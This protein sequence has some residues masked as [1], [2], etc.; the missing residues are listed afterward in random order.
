M[1]KAFTLLALSV[2]CLAAQ[3]QIPNGSFENWT[4]IGSYSI[5][6]GWDNFNS[7]TSSS[8]I[9]TCEKGTT[10]APNGSAYLKLTTKTVGSSLV[11]GFAQTGVYDFTNKTPKS[12]FAFT[13]RPASLTGKWQYMASGSDTSRIAVYLTKWNSTTGQTDLIA[14]VEYNLPGM[15]MSWTSFSIPLTYYSNSA[16]DSAIVAAVTSN[17][18]VTAAAG[19]YLYLDSLNFA[20]T[21]AGIKG[22][23]ASKYKLIVSPNP[24]KDHISIDFGT[25]TT[26]DAVIS[27]TDLFG[28]IVTEATFSKGNRVYN[29]HLD[30]MPQGLYMVKVKVGDEVQAQ[31]LMVQ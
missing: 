5:P 22:V 31:K 13:G 16:P 28:R 24:A 1:K 3:A 30:A 20:G 6:D 15:V 9:Y 14:E 26:D 10:G 27:V 7:Q 21:A 25:T 2:V 18:S 4:T 29:M 17:R 19:T 8:S 12:G 23:N 11:P